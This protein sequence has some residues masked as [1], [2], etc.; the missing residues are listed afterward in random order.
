MN[1]PLRQSTPDAHRARVLRALGVMPW[2]Q[3]TAPAAPRQERPGMD[4]AAGVACVVVLPQGCDTR[5]LDLIGRALSAFGAAFARSARVTLSGGELV[6]VPEA[7]AYL[8][9]GEAQARALG[10]AL[11]AAAMHRAQIVL[12]DEPASVLTSAAGKRRLWN[13]LRALRRAMPAAEH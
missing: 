11:P 10:R 12:A 1:M 9:F 5:E 8:V 3:R 2:V 4:S 6:N 7:R 13:A